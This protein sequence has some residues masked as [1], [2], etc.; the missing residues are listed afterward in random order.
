MKVKLAQQKH[1]NYPNPRSGE[2]QWLWSLPF[3]RNPR[4][5]LV[6]RVRHASTH[7]WDGRRSHDTCVYWCGN[8]GRGD[9]VDDPGD[10]LVCARCE[11]MAVA[12]GEKT[13]DELV[14]RHVHLGKLIARRVCCVELEN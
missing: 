7:L 1:T 9:F 10:L 6:H 13:S 12:N 3:L 14:G 2:V 5:Y 4:G 8:V 11:A